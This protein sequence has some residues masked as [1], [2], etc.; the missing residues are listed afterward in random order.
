MPFDSNLNIYDEYDGYNGEQVKQA[1]VVMLTYPL[2]FP[3][4]SGVGLNDLNYYA[5]RTDL[6]GP[7]MTDA[8]HS[9]DASALNAP[10]CSA[11]TYMLRS[12]EPFLR[13]PYDQF[14][15]TRTGPNTGFNFLTGVGGF[16]QVF[17]Y[18]YSG[19]RFGPTSIQLDPSLSPQLHGI[20]LNNLQWQGRDFTVNIGPQ[21]TQVQL[22][23]GQPM[24]VQ[25]P[26]GMQTVAAGS[27]LTLPTRRPDEQPTSD[28][29][30]CQSVTASSF[31]P[32]DEPAAAV[33]GSTATPWEATAPQATLTVQLSA[34]T[35]LRSATV[36]RGSTG[37]FSYKVE[38]S[39]D[40]STWK[41]VATSP[42]S[43]T[44]TDQFRFPPTKAQF[45]RLDFPGG[46][47]TDAP[48]IDE[49]SVSP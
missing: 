44:G 5:P 24:P 39:T 3:M 8:I 27:T 26:S 17:E 49:L 41:V 1:D 20:T 37:T 14:A 4:A 6:Q 22:S 9:I 10:G 40:G 34:T 2:G 21:S 33:D 38:T 28:L 47:G 35:Q 48:A 42:S 25:T 29:A 7:A 23:S 13:A 36:T 46:S 12:Y 45:V 11:Y 15:E 32:G 18:G 30:R 19:L 31:V 43:S 16:L